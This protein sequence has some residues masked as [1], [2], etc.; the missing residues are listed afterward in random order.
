MR[1][2]PLQ[3]LA[4]DQR[5]CAV[6]CWF[7]KSPAVSPLVWVGLVAQEPEKLSF[8]AQFLSA[9]RAWLAWQLVVADLWA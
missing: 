4:A 7:V 2:P 3:L 5:G 8:T 6:Q 1:E 9:L